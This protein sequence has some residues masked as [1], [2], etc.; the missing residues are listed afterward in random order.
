[1]NYTV[2]DRKL[3]FIEDDEK[4]KKETVEYF[5]AANRVLT[6]SDVDEAVDILEKNGDVDAVVLDLILKRSMGM[7]L[8]KAAPSLPPVII[9]S[10]LDGEDGILIGEDS[11]IRRTVENNRMLLLIGAI[12]KW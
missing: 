11:A 6:A 3:L 5:S 8:F 1:M 10:S 4:L 7:D 9:L 12:A 2:C